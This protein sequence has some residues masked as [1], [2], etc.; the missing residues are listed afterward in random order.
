MSARRGLLSE[1][2]KRDKSII[3]DDE[4]LTRNNR[5]CETQKKTQKTRHKACTDVATRPKRKRCREAQNFE[6]GEK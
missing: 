2:A 1:N 4:N 5:V 3:A 6:E